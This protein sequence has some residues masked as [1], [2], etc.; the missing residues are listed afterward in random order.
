VEPGELRG[1]AGPLHLITTLPQLVGHLVDGHAE[2]GH[3]LAGSEQVDVLGRPLRYAVLADCTGAGQSE[4][5]DAG[6]RDPG[7]ARWTAT[8]RPGSEMCSLMTS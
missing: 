7:E 2:R 4:A 5:V 1:A 3:V 8:S 6:E